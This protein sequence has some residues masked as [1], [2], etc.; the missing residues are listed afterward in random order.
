MTDVQKYQNELASLYEKI[1]HPGEKEMMGK[2]MSK[3]ENARIEAEKVVPE[4]LRQI[5]DSAR[6]SAAQAKQQLAE[7]EKRKKQ[8]A[9]ETAAADTVKMPPA[10]K[11]KQEVR[12]D[13]KLGP[14]LRLELLQRFAQ[15]ADGPARLSTIKEAWEDWQ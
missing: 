15:H 4:T 7:I 2:L 8:M 13:P 3:I 14:T 6:C 11:P 12:V 1:T 10:A 5:Q 9:A